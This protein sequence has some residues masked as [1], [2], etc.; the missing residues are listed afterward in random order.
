MMYIEDA[1]KAFGRSGTDALMQL[2]DGVREFFKRLPADEFSGELIFIVVIPD[3]NGKENYLVRNNDPNFMD[4]GASSL[5]SARMVVKDAPVTVI[6][7]L[8]SQRFRMCTADETPL[9]TVYASQAIV[10]FNQYGKDQFFIGK[11]S[12]TMPLLVSGSRSNFSVQ[13]ISELNEALELYGS[14]AANVTCPILSDVWI[15]GQDGPRLVFENKPE[16]KMRDSLHNFLRN[17]LRGDVT[18]RKE[19]N[20]NK[21]KPID[22]S[23]S[24]F[25]H[26]LKALI[27]IKW[28]GASKSSSGALTRYYPSRVQVGANQLIDYMDRES[29]SDPNCVIRG[30]LVVFD[31]RRKGLKSSGD[32]L[33]ANKDAVHYRKCKIILTNDPASTRD[34]VEPLIRYFLEPRSSFFS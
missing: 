9:I 12:Q 15:G 27:E 1:R 8:A 25:G 30:Y 6:Q 5:A 16:S 11:Y 34:D 14:D 4:L 2:L 20:T 13:T 29:G 21:N 28:L 10:L 7:I 32:V 33:L 19:H 18:V 24:W 23:I 22:L 17:R 31:G 26:A 3:A